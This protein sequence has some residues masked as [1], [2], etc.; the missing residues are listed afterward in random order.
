[1]LLS[2]IHLCIYYLS[3]RIQNIQQFDPASILQ[4]IFWLFLS[5][6]IWLWLQEQVE[7]FDVIKRTVCSSKDD[8]GMSQYSSILFEMKLDN[9]FIQVFILTRLQNSMYNCMT[10][11]SDLAHLLM[12][13]IKC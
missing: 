8:E 5:N 2:Y 4:P 10:G 6:E 13:K 11:D 12:L 7:I 3:I 9:S 1:M